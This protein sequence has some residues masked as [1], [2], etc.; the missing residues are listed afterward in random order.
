MAGPTGC[1]KTAIAQAL[2]KLLDVPFVVT[3]GTSLT[4]AGYVGEDVES[5]IK[6]LWIAADRDVDRASRGIVVIDEIDKIARRGDSGASTRDVG[7]EGVQQALQDD[8]ERHRHDLPDGARTR[9]HKEL[10]QLTRPTS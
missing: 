3:D 1:G 6:S 2:A 10:I 5:I 7:G 9:P 8:R 4:E